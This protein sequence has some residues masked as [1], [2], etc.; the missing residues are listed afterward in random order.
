[1]IVLPETQFHEEEK[2]SNRCRIVV[3]MRHLF[4][5]QSTGTCSAKYPV[6]LMKY[7]FGSLLQQQSLCHVPLSLVVSMPLSL[8]DVPVISVLVS[9]SSCKMPF[10]CPRNAVMVARISLQCYKR[11][12]LFHKHQSLML[13]LLLA[14]C[15]FLY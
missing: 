13:V 4:C 11:K 9:K 15:P 5:L 1:V 12:Q 10:L 14:L 2:D 3:Y 7:E 6:A 8:S